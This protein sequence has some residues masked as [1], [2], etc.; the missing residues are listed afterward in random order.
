MCGYNEVYMAQDMHSIA[1]IDTI[2]T[3]YNI[4]SPADISRILKERL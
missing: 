4:I 3:D 1:S 2:I